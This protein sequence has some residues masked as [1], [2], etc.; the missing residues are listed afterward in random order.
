MKTN[1]EK[2]E[3]T[4]KAVNEKKTRIY[5]LIVLD[6]SGS[7][8]SIRKAAY[9][10]CNEVLSGIRA[11]AEKHKDDQEQFVSLLL[12]DTESM[13]YIYRCTPA[14]ETTNLSEK[15]YKPCAATPLL[16]AMG[17]S[18]LALRN[19]V[20][21][22][23]DAVGMV[24]II[25]DG[26][27]NASKEF[28]YGKIQELVESL[29]QQ[30]WNFAFMGA[31]QDITKVCLDLNI[32]VGNAIAFSFDEQGMHDAWEKDM[33]AKE[34][35][36]ERM[37][38]VKEQ[39]KDMCI[40]ER[41][42]HYCMMN[43]NIGYFKEPVSPRTTPERI[44]SLSP[45]EVFVFGSNIQGWHNGGAAQYALNHFGAVM[46][47][48]EGMQGQS[49]AIP[50]TGCSLLGISDAVARFT[51]YARQHPEKHFLVTAIGCGVAGYQPADI[52][53]MFTD[54]SLLENVSLPRSF[55]KILR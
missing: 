14:A 50:T 48:P 7:M 32:N 31:N 42:M 20:N 15:D 30:G 52:A 37:R 36:Y 25:T 13:P 41:R 54:A 19:E 39:T 17:K 49:Y 11:A 23:E 45:D 53:P 27:E 43:Q 4:E 51:D 9:D 46:G 2:T 12:F 24:T 21:K 16:D 22:Y 26:Y 18:L 38:E 44:V 8:N 34:R 40:E 3:N 10:G 33:E 6:K 47:Q 5:N 29:K 35:Y 55:W 1:I 28:T